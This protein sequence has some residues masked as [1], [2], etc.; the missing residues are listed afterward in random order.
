MIAE[1]RYLQMA[2]SKNSRKKSL[3]A[4]RRERG[5]TCSVCQSPDYTMTE[6]KTHPDFKPDFTCTN[7]HSWQH[8]KDGGK[9]A[10][11]ASQKDKIKNGYKK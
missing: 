10:E 5:A 6:N 7:G 1:R 2:K 9:Y 11:L 4:R 3:V 8:G